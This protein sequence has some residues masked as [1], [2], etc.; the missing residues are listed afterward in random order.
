MLS[1]LE[2]KCLNLLYVSNLSEEDAAKKMNMEKKFFIKL[3]KRAKNKLE[4]PA[5][6]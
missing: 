5:S 4:R 3:V 6:V 1:Q 2:N